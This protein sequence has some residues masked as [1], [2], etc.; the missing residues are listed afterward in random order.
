MVSNHHVNLGGKNTLRY[1]NIV[2][3]L[4]NNYDFTYFL[5]YPEKYFTNFSE[6]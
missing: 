6:I 2:K 5:E 3:K 1:T 4:L